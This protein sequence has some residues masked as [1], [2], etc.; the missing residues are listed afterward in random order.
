MLKAGIGEVYYLGAC[1][2]IHKEEFE[3]GPH[4]MVWPWRRVFYTGRKHHP[5]FIRSEVQPFPFRKCGLFIKR[6][7]LTFATRRCIVSGV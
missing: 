6:F 5:Y 7:H 1:F 4:N 2:H 3:V